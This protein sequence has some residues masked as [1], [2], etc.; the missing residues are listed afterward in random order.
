MKFKITKGTII[1][2]IMIGIV[3]INM[4]LKKFGINI[5]N[6]DENAADAL[7]T[8]FGGS[9]SL[10]NHPWANATF[11]EFAWDFKT[12]ERAVNNKSTKFT[13]TLVEDVT[14]SGN[15]FDRSVTVSYD[16]TIDLNNH[17]ISA[18]GNEKITAT[19]NKL[20]FVGNGKVELE[21]DKIIANELVI[22]GG[23]WIFDPTAWLADGYK[24]VKNGSVWTVTKE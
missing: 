5:I 20:T 6:T 19:G 12:L 17:T 16:A 3:L 1:R 22:K 9:P 7:A 21:K 18:N 14:L 24:T 23:T 10:V 4:I 2:T 8:C 11:G 15:L 13:A